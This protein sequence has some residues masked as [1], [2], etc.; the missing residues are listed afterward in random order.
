MRNVGLKLSTSIAILVMAAS[1]GGEDSPAPSM[2]AIPSAQ[3]N[4]LNPT[5]REILQNGGTFT[6]PLSAMPSNFNYWEI[7]GSEYGTDN[8]ISA[9]MPFTHRTTANALPEWS[10]E[11]LAS[12]P[13]LVVEPQQ[14]VI[15]RINPEAA[16]YDGTP[17]TWEDFHWHWYATSG[18]DSAYRIAASN[19]YEQIE[20]VERGA[21]DREVIVTFASPFAAWQNLFTPMYPA[22]TTRDPEAFNNGWRNAPQTTAGPFKLEGIDQTSK[23]IT[24]IRNETWWG[25]APILDRIVYRVIVPDA[26][27]DA[28]ANGEIDAMDIGADAN[29]YSRAVRLDGIDIRSAGGPNF[30]HITVNGSSPKL[31]D[32]RVRQA[33]AMAIDR[34][35]LARALIEPLGIEP[36]TL[37]NHIFMANQYGYQ[38]NSGDVGSYDSGR[39]AEILDGLGWRINGEF[40]SRNGETLELSFVI[41]AGIAG[42]RQEGEL[43][44]NMFGQIGVRLNIL[45]VPTDDFFSQY[46]I[47][48]EYD[49]TVFTWVGDPYP[50][51][52]IKSIYAEPVV[53]PD[54]EFDIQQ[55]FARVGSP[56]LNA[57][58][59]EAMAEFD[60]DRAAILANEADAMIWELVHSLTVYQRPELIATRENLANFGA[61]AFS[62]PWAYE[63]IGWIQDS[64]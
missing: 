37:G 45:T 16:W 3:G 43:I 7:D 27:V 22:S 48:G 18:Q 47:P 46:I 56:E 26:Q 49:F 38:D 35:V 23:T 13:E 11:Y 40:R 8:V 39:A 42:A 63:D 30:R 61:F 5:P 19:G 28:L 2:T 36:V 15:Y 29:R 57:K 31:S 44:Q 62:R 1:C 20:S 41:P 60:R 32:V 54:G 6:W 51:A 9:L 53:G 59:D 25:P 55:N 64:E 12:A 34:S 52:S 10:R 24:L 14:V 33:L 21:D 58:M 17:I 50:L 4:D